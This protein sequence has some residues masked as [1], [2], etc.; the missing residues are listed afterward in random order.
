[1]SLSAGLRYEYSHTSNEADKQENQVDRKIGMFFPS[2]FLSKKLSEAW[3]IQFSYTKRISRPTFNDLTSYLMY[4][5]PMSVGTGNPSLQPTLT[6][7]VRAGVNY[8][9]Y[10]FSLLASH[11][12]HPIVLY[13][14]SESPAGDIMYNNPQN[15]AYQ[16]SLTFQTDLSINLFPWWS[17][18]ISL[19]GSW[20]QFKLSHTDEKLVKSYTTASLNGRQNFLLPKNFSL[21]ISGWY[22]AVQYDGSKELD[23]F[24]ML[25]AGLKKELGKQGSVQLTVT[26]L[27]KSMQVSG[28]FG[29]LTDEAFSVYA[30]FI[31]KA[32]SANNRIVKLTYTRSFG[33]AKTKVSERNSISEDER[34]RI[35]K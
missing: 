3:E 21:E 30:H 35:K 11:D 24:G 34:R 27:L 20:R 29:T 22:N 31:Y 10:T 25:N 32:E 28:H 7:N 26:D 4:I 19:I 14:L 33:N 9:G 12:K 13:Q 16:K 6:N 5:D 1:L 15:M 17:M 2:V 18:N 8:K 23:G